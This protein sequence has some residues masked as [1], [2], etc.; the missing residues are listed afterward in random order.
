MINYYVT[1]SSLGV[2][3]ADR[4]SVPLWAAVLSCSAGMAWRSGF[5]ACGFVKHVLNTMNKRDGECRRIVSEMFEFH[6]AAV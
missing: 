4:A 1:V 3:L 2:R 6:R 5:H